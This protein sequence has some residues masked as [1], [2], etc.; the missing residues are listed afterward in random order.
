MVVYIRSRI[1]RYTPLS[2]ATNSGNISIVDI[3]LKSGKADLTSRDVDGNTAVHIALTNLYQGCSQSPRNFW[4]WGGSAVA[5]E[6][7]F[8]ECV[9][10]LVDY[11]QKHCPT[12]LTAENAVGLTP[13]GLLI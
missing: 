1:Q 9:G 12:I 2:L 13:N 10:S 7:K 4:S 11:A 8:Y 3:I 5:E 6:K